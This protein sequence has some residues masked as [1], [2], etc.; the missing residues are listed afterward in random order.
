MHNLDLDL[1]LNLFIHMF[2][3]GSTEGLYVNMVWK[4]ELNT[5]NLVYKFLN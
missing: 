1:D 5:Y 4:K 3:P 2:N